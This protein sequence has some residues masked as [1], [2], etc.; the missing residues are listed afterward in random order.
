MHAASASQA[1]R[2][3]D[4]AREHRNPWVAAGRSS[5]R[6]P[7]AVPDT[8][9]QASV[10]SLEKA[11]LLG[12]YPTFFEIMSGV[13]VF[14]YS[15]HFQITIPRSVSAGWRRSSL[16][17][18]QQGLIV[19]VPQPLPPLP[20]GIGMLEPDKYLLSYLSNLLYHLFHLFLFSHL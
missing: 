4:T 12:T 20:W 19:L 18:S 16:P 10:N 3:G 15:S 9:S 13:L 5:N 7:A 2:G 8:S 1:I 14:I 17:V 11:Y 6:S